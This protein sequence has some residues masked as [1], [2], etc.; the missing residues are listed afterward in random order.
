[1]Q[2]KNTS[3]F[4]FFGNLLGAG[5]MLLLSNGLPGQDND[6]CITCHEDSYFAHKYPHIEVPRVVFSDTVHARFDCVDCHYTGYEDY[7]HCNKFVAKVN[8]AECHEKQAQDYRMSGHHQSRR[9]GNL[10]APDC[11]DCHSMHAIQPPESGLQGRRS[12]EL[13][14]RCHANEAQSARFQLKGNVVESF[15]TSYHGQ[16]YNLGFEGS[17]YA[18]CVSCHDNHAILASDQPGSTVGRE[19]IVETCAQCHDGANDHFVGY[20]THYS[21]DDDRHFLLNLVFRSMELLL[22][23]VMVVFGLHTLLWFLITVTR[24]SKEDH[25]GHEHRPKGPRKSVIRFKM[26]ERIQHMI[27]ALAF[28]VLAFTGLPLKFSESTISKWVATHLIGFEQAALLHRVAGVVMLLLFAFH[29][30][31]LLWKILV[32]KRWDYLW[33][34]NSL[35][36][37]PRDLVEFWGHLKYFLHLRPRPPAFSRWT[38]WEKFDYLA[39]F[40]GMLVIG[41]S[42]LVLMMPLFVTKWLPGWVINACHIVHSEEALLATAFI[43]VV[44][45]FNTHLRPA[46]FPMDDSI[47]T[48][49]V[50]VDQL[51]E[52][53]PAEYEELVAKGK[54]AELEAK[55]LVYWK[56]VLVRLVGFLFLFTGLALLF[57]ILSSLI[58]H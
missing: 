4:R 30:G 9:S 22:V 50:S 31:L 27:M 2:T 17:R 52:E 57:W 20:L 3:H 24:R 47:F 43:F 10:S 6:T 45:F 13:C 15:K 39:V 44:H 18:T 46:A 28:L 11:V 54:L 14:S 58:F 36:P 51:K 38:Y 29:V 8:C 56:V 26:H 40:W 53:R 5:L 21:P 55:P 7:P 32:N 23:S 34:R 16:M 41:L 19:R 37:Q 1:M 49:R 35:V 25:E 33:G 48:G 42:G 12:V